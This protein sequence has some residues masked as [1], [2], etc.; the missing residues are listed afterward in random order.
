M[1]RI[2]TILFFG[3]LFLCLSG[4]NQFIPTHLSTTN[5][6]PTNTH[7]A[8]GF[9]HKNKLWISSDKGIHSFNGRSIVS[10]PIDDKYIDDEVFFFYE[11]S[12]KRK[13]LVNYNG[14]LSYLSQYFISNY[15]QS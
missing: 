3:V 12:K 1:N 4:K 2:K 13:W 14:Q 15:K 10:P 5:G 7:Y 9:D 11:D 8:V 6:L